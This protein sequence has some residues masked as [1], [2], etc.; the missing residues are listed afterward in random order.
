MLF[1]TG[2]QLSTSAQNIL[3]LQTANINGST[4]ITP[5]LPN[6]FKLLNAS[7]ID[8]AATVK[9]LNYTQSKADDP[10]LYQAQN[11]LQVYHVDKEAK[12][13]DIFFSD[14]AGYIK[15]VEDDF[16]AEYPDARHVSLNDGI[17]G[18]DFTV[19]GDYYETSHYRICFDLPADG[20]GGV[21]LLDRD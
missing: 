8:F 2:I 21:T 19:V 18:Y 3:S 12:M 14:N 7:G 17:E 9:G 16:L 1:I 20:G 11:S 4:V 15:K 5:V 10:N 13:I 6:L